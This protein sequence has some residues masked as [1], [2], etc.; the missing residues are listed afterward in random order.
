MTILKRSHDHSQ[1]AETLAIGGPS[2]KP[3]AAAAAAAASAAGASEMDWPWIITAEV[4]R[5]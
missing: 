4:N 2:L 1:S 5:P 3:H